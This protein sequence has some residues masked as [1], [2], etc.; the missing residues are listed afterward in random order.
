MVKVIKFEMAIISSIRLTKVISYIREQ[1]Y[2]GTK[3]P[4][5]ML[6]ET[7]QC[8]EEFLKVER[9]ILIRKTLICVHLIAE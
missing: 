3:K 7:A 2:Q 6:S 4:S 9:D 8:Q 1:L 5:L